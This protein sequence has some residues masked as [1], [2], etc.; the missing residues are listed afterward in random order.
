MKLEPKRKRKHTHIFFCFRF[1]TGKIYYSNNNGNFSFHLE[2]IH[3]NCRQFFHHLRLLSRSPSLS[4]SRH[5][6][7]FLSRFSLSQ[8]IALFPHSPR[9]IA[10][11]FNGGQF[12]HN[13]R[14]KNT[15]IKTK[16]RRL[17]NDIN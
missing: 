16:Y 13:K 8:E 1:Q 9:L 5:V 14:A 11:Q 7:L 3:F 17:K 15:A 10:V 6:P 12:R 2:L 4:L